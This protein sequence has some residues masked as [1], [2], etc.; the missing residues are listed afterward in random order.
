MEIKNGIFHKNL[1][2]LKLLL[3]NNDYH[4]IFQK[5]KNFNI[6]FKKIMKKHNSNM[7]N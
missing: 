1:K 4:Q 5:E 6:L 3:K 7:I 2:I